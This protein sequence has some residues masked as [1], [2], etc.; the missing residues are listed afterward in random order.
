MH[1]TAPSV[2]SSQ[3]QIDPSQFML[4]KLPGR[5]SEPLLNDSPQSRL[6]EA[7]PN[8]VLSRTK[9]IEDI[10]ESLHA[11]SDAAFLPNYLK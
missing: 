11:T 10:P 9:E 8:D 4:G 2:Q 3:S 1:Y 7:F 6:A 5:S